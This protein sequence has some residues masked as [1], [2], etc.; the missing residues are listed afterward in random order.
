MTRDELE[1]VIW[2]HGVRSAVDVHAILYA[3]DAYATAQAADAVSEKTAQAR[4]RAVL[5]AATRPS[6]DVLDRQ[7]LKAAAAAATPGGST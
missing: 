7:L 4:R 2:R 6:A 3:A 1:S 5:A